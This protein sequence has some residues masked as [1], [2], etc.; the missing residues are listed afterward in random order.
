MT[1]F[2][3]PA[4][5]IMRR[6]AAM[7]YDTL[8][9]LAVL[10]VATGFAV[11]ANKGQAVSHPLYY[12]SLVVICFLFFG[13]FWTHGGQ[14]LGMRTW[15]LKLLSKDS[16]DISWSMAGR[17]FVFASVALLP[18]GAGLLWMLFDSQ[19][20]AIHDRLSETK[21]VFIPKL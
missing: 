16:R 21:I 13:W 2:N 8:L 3:L 12:L 10:F 17:R 4:A 14:T 9:L 19:R 1:E 20:L 15:R 7:V 5:G 6:I 11:A 18:C